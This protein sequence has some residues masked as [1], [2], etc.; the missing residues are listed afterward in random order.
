MSMVAA[1]LSEKV[2]D[3]W[4]DF[5]RIPLSS[6]KTGK[7]VTP[8]EFSEMLRHLQYEAA[9]Q[10][11]TE[12]GSWTTYVRQN[13]V[14]PSFLPQEGATPSDSIVAMY[15]KN[16]GATRFLFMSAPGTKVELVEV[17]HNSN[18][19]AQDVLKNEGAMTKW[20]LASLVPAIVAG[21][22][23]LEGVFYALG[24]P[25]PFDQIGSRRAVFDSFVA[26]ASG[27]LD[28]GATLFFGNKAWK[29][30]V[31]TVV[32]KRMANPQDYLYGGAA[33]E[34]IDRETQSKRFEESVQAAYDALPRPGTEVDKQD[35]YKAFVAINY[36][37]GPEIE[38]IA[39]LGKVSVPEV[40]RAIL[41]S[42]L[43]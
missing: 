3:G 1:S 13:Y 6:T 14:P 22:A 30:S 8:Q 21:P 16:A 17:I 41:A 29:R 10:F 12:K 42:Q 25:P 34:V 37:S 31:D 9:D 38:E 20:F 39:A 5:N 28:F 2:L 24:S 7:L 11:S 4:V 43:S 23:V 32:S 33:G 18:T 26:L 36:L 15:A 27:A 19:L 35:F 40:A